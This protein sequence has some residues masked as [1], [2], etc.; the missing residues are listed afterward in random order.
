MAPSDMIAV[1][2][3]R[4]EGQLEEAFEGANYISGVDAYLEDNSYHS[5]RA[6]VRERAR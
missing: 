1:L 6:I 4:A 5:A 2:G 3:D